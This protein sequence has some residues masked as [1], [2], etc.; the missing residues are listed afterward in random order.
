MSLVRDPCAASIIEY[1]DAVPFGKWFFR[2]HFLSH[3]KR[4]TTAIEADL[5]FN[6]LA[7][8]HLLLGVRS[9]YGSKAGTSD[10]CQCSAGTAADLIAE[11][12]AGHSTKDGT[13][14]GASF[15]FH[16][17]DRGDPALFDSLGLAYLAA[18]VGVTGEA[19]LGARN[20]EER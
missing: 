5:N 19:L 17:A 1:A 16:V 6:P 4:T 3:G 11:D 20:H 18:R 13:C 15:D 2:I 7:A 14:G 9:G 8:A 12:T 10:G